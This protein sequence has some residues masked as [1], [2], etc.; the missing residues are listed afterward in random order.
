MRLAP[1]VTVLVACASSPTLFAN[2]KPIAP[3]RARL[4]AAGGDPAR[5]ITLR[6]ASDLA[7]LDSGERYKFA[8]T[9]AGALRIAPLPAR[10]PNNEYVHPILADGAPVRTAGMI[11]VTRE[12]E[13]LT[14]I[15]LDRDSRAYCPTEESLA[16]ALDALVALGL[17]RARL[18]TTPVTPQC[19]PPLP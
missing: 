18:R 2:R 6:G 12:G 1:L 4:A 13:S 17:P 5:V 8:L 10:A 9:A 19:E 11:T 15:T 14:A 3:L 16:H 7:A